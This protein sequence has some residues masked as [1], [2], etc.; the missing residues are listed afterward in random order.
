MTT[1][2]WD[3]VGCIESR[4]W[5]CLYHRVQLENQ[6]YNVIVE[7]DVKPE[8]RDKIEANI[9]E[10]LKSLGTP[11]QGREE[12]VHKTDFDGHTVTIEKVFKLGE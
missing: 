1:P 12:T 6:H 4:R 7:K 11:D 5:S 10:I 2:S 8:D 3:P 9:V